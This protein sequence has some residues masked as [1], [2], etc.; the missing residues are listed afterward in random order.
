MHAVA[1]LVAVHL[2]HV[3]F[4]HSVTRYT[5]IYHDEWLNTEYAQQAG[6]RK[7]PYNKRHCRFCGSRSKFLG[8]TVPAIL[9]K[10]VPY[11]QRYLVLGLVGLALRL[12]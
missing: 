10:W 6:A 7:I 5:L 9:E 3:I 1:W 4:L 12:V 2:V 11:S 8:E